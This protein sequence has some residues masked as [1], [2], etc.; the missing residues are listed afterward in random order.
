MAEKFNQ[1]ISSEVQKIV[2]TQAEKQGMSPDDLILHILAQTSQVNF[3]EV[4][5]SLLKSGTDR[6][7]I[8]SE[9]KLREDMEFTF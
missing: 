6:Q 9:L 4:F 1:S 8:V 3:E 5:A 2:D 7:T